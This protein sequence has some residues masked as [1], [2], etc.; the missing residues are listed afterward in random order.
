MKEY[1]LSFD[2]SVVPLLAN[3]LSLVFSLRTHKQL[4][5]RHSAEAAEVEHGKPR[6]WS[7]ATSVAILLAATALIA[8]ISEMLV[9]SV[10]AAA[11]SVGNVDPS[12]W[13]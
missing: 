11:E 8:W 6:G 4:F 5:A 13:A 2:I 7:V 1:N 3:A 12:L 9:A 10:E